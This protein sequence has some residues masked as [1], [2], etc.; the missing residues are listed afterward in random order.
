ML[1]T[2]QSGVEPEQFTVE[3]DASQRGQ[4]LTLLM[5]AAVEF[6]AETAAPDT[7]NET[8]ALVIGL[9]L[10]VGVVLIA[11][12]LWMLLRLVRAAET[13]ARNTRPPE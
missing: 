11:F 8:S 3:V 6:S 9:F 2:T 4:V 7:P 12:V 5:A 10:A 13:I 1:V